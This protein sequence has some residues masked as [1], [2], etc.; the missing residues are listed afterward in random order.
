[1]SLIDGGQRPGDGLVERFAQALEVSAPE[2]KDLRHVLKEE[3]FQLRLDLA[4]RFWLRA[5][6]KTSGTQRES[7]GSTSLCA[8]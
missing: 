7:W 5:K 1:M 3:I 2:V 4:R 6:S 8:G